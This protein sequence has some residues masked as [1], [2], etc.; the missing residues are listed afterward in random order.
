MDSTTT[1]ATAKPV[2]VMASPRGP[3]R[4]EDFVGIEQANGRVQMR[5]IHATRIDLALK[6]LKNSGHF[7]SLL[8]Q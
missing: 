5:Q 2:T 4:D 8:A 1:L 3:N 7:Q 6:V